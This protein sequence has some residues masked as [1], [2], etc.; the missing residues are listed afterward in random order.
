MGGVNDGEMAPL[1]PTSISPTPHSPYMRNNV[2][3]FDKGESNLSSLLKKPR[4]H[5][6]GGEDLLQFPPDSASIY[7]APSMLSLHS[8]VESSKHEEEKVKQTV[9]R[10]FDS[11][12]KFLKENGDYQQ[13]MT[14]WFHANRSSCT[15]PHQRREAT[16]ESPWPPTTATSELE[17]ATS[18]S[19]LSSLSFCWER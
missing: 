1:V 7:S 11:V 3:Y 15:V 6:L 19:P 14:S 17:A 12:G 5:Y 2:I 4:V 16:V 9:L 10:H 13:I 8:A 18:C